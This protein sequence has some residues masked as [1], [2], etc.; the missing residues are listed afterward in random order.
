MSV[1]RLALSHS[2]DDKLN[3]T[4]KEAS[5]L[6]TASLMTNS[7][8]LSPTFITPG[9]FD[10]NGK[11]DETD[12]SGMLSDCQ[13]ITDLHVSLNIIENHETFEINNSTQY[14]TDNSTSNKYKNEILNLKQQYKN[15]NFSNQNID[16]TING[17]RQ[18]NKCLQQINYDNSFE[19]NID[20]VSLE[21]CILTG[22]T[23]NNNEFNMEQCNKITEKTYFDVLSNKCDDVENN[24]TL[25]NI[26]KSMN[27]TNT[28]ESIQ[29][30]N[31][32]NV[33]L[34][35][36]MSLESRS[37]LEKI[38][39]NNKM[40]AKNK[41]SNINDRSLNTDHLLKVDTF[42]SLENDNNDKVSFNKE[43][44][45]LLG[46]S[47][48]YITEMENSKE[49]ISD[50][51]EVELSK[52]HVT[53]N[54]DIRMFEKNNSAKINKDNTDYSNIEYFA[55]ELKACEPVLNVDFIINENDID[56]IIKDNVINNTDENTHV[57]GIIDDYNNTVEV[58]SNKKGG[59]NKY[60]SE[61]MIL[62]DGNGLTT[63]FDQ[64][65]NDSSNLNIITENTVLH[66]M[67][68]CKESPV[69]ELHQ[70]STDTNFD[71]SVNNNISS[72]KLHSNKTDPMAS[73]PVIASYLNQI[74]IMVAK[75][76]K[77]K[78]YNRGKK[79]SLINSKDNVITSKLCIQGV[80]KPGGV[81][82]NRRKSSST[83]TNK[84]VVYKTDRIKTY[85]KCTKVRRDQS[86]SIDNKQKEML[87]CTKSIDLSSFSPNINENKSHI[88]CNCYDFG[89]LWFDDEE[90][91]HVHFANN[92]SVNCNHE[93]LFSEK[94]QNDNDTYEQAIDGNKDKLDE[95]IDFSDSDHSNIC[96]K[97]IDVD[98]CS[99]SSNSQEKVNISP[100]EL[101]VNAEMPVGEVILSET[102][103]LDETQEETDEDAKTIKSV[104]N[105][106]ILDD[107]VRIILNEIDSVL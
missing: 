98:S 36:N 5:I 67:S 38:V 76:K 105:D 4:D 48:E 75:K 55:N 50:I 18:N 45:V 79:I 44:E 94:Y 103:I 88:F 20:L 95:N 106:K 71:N 47:Y 84:L 11:V 73:V 17:K 77:Y 80:E 43:N 83:K 13:E 37:L 33:S 58:S 27:C 34:Q 24:D 40:L 99:L 1:D 8:F 101:H 41:N 82:T 22:D 7:V 86:R 12:T 23:I 39:N 28:S 35:N 52:D 107:D 72:D 25:S 42:V 21:G 104:L 89:S 65:V 10:I 91:L 69:Y 56:N 78:R 6:E 59:Q 3:G 102:N 81:N 68:S 66:E 26:L 2:H 19:T 70:N 54:N 60:D 31:L 62:I 93:V 85:K 57:N 14:D 46:N 9:N 90:Y 87:N 97:S 32:N 100:S 29:N 96:W 63:S 49:I 15:N 64:D 53:S 61:E 16:I 30:N 74:A 51:S 92:V